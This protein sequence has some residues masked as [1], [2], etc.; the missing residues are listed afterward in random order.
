MHAFIR[1][2]CRAKCASAKLKSRCGAI[3][4]S[5]F[6][7]R[8]RTAPVTA[9]PGRSNTRRTA[10][11]QRR[12]P[13][14]SE[15]GNIRAAVTA[16]PSAIRARDR[17][18]P[19]P[20]ISALPSPVVRAGRPTTSLLPLILALRTCPRDQP[21][22]STSALGRCRYHLRYSRPP[23]RRFSLSRS[24]MHPGGCRIAY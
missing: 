18:H 21:S 19:N 13:A 15:P 5:W 24:F 20:E 22:R 4:P 1:I 23:A 10:S 9:T 11:R 14:A 17:R 8:P 16:S 7:P 6:W 2:N 12:H 3:W